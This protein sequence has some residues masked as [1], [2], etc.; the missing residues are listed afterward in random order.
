MPKWTDG[1]EER[2]KQGEAVLGGCMLDDDCCGW[3]CLRCGTRF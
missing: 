3:E 1:L 2:L